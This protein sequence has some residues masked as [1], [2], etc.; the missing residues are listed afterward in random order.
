MSLIK[1]LWLAIAVVMTLA[2]GISLVVSVYSARHYLQQQLQLKNIDNATSLALSLTQMEKDPVSVELQVSAQFDAGHYRYIK[3]VS[4][5]GEP[6]LE[7]TYK[8]PEANVPTWFVSLFPIQTQPGRAQIQDGWKQYGTLTLASHD[9]FAYQSLWNG[10]WE[11]LLW[12]L[13]GSVLT[14]VVGTW[15]VKLITRPLDDVVDQA[16]GITERRFLTI[17]EPRTPELRS[18]V[19]ALNG[20]VLRLKTMF[21]EEANRLDALRKKFNRDPVTG[22]S[23]RAYFLSHLREVLTGEQFG[24][25]GSLVVVRLTD[26][27]QIN[28]TL[29]GKRTDTLLQSLGSVLYQSSNERPGQRA[30][31][32]KGAEFGVICP[33]FAS[34]TEAAQDIH[35]RLLQNWLPEWSGEMS[36]LFHV[37][38][39]PY[40]REQDMGQLLA[41]ADEAL[42]RA[43][44]LG[45]NSLYASPAGQARQALGSEQWRTLLTEAVSGGRLQLAFFPVLSGDGSSAMHQESVIRLQT[46]QQGGLMAAGDFMPMAAQLNLTAP[47]DLRVVR[48]AI[49]HLS[50]GSGNVAVNLSA[51]TLAD[52]GFRTQLTQLLKAYPEMCKRLLFEVPEYGVF[53]QFEAFRDLVNTLKQL[54]C[55]VGIEYFGQR[56]QDA[57]KLTGLGLDYVKV[58]PTYIRDISD[59]TGNQE[60]LKGLCAMAHAF[61]IEVIAL[62]VESADD[63]PLLASLGFDGATGPGIGK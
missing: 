14:G 2:F 12:F 4:P 26:L 54:G 62:G 63:L 51:D 34:P 19:R 59:N 46:D 22:L 30:G 61:G 38:A 49:E 42:A 1:Q 17:N 28:A 18:V 16:H 55:R 44:S 15:A 6:L 7:K 13:L 39:V 32:L 5:K 60:F 31:R 43:Q 21:A 41:Q 58:H 52:Y 56:F 40:S 24:A 47:I 10:S 50:K 27:A 57:D 33:S 20:M 53:R 3:I 48:L 9:S 23:S 37:A 45:P 11:L 29:G 35:G 25:E 8:G 36:D